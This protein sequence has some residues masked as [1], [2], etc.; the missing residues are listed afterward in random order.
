MA[1]TVS[2]LVSSLLWFTFTMRE[3][4]T[5]LIEM[6]I[7]V[8]NLPED[9][10]LSQL[11]PRAARVQ[12]VG[13][14]WSLLRLYLNPP[15]ITVNAAQSE[16]NLRGVLPELPKNVDVQAVTPSVV[17]LV[18]EER[19][20]RTLP[21]EPR[22]R[23]ET[24][25]THDLVEP[26]RIIPDSVEVSGAE[27]VVGA[28]ESWPTARRSFENVRDT[29]E[30]RVPLSDTLSGLVVKSVDAVT[31]RAVSDEFTQGTRIIDVT[32][33]GQPSTRTLVS[34]EPSRIKV[35]Y[36]V[37]FS[38]FQE[39]QN[40]MDFYATVSYDDIR[41]DTTGRIEPDVH[42]PDGLTIRNVRFSPRRLG[43]YERIE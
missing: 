11:P 26:P 29:L 1:I 15:S 4:H 12:V 2:I 35:T 40:A 10:S 9:E 43:Y 8:V 23:I 22:I 38:Q 6:P 36:R 21:I 17:T 41:N 24:P 42:V 25:A 16:V 30:V 7:S 34:L 39:A 3:R 20:T 32:V 13:D 33:Q 14:G 31:V 37:L 18:K 28:L 5:K 27:S 19:I